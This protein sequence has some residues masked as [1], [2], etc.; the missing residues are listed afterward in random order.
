MAAHLLKFQEKQDEL[1][2]PE[3]PFILSETMKVCQVWH[4]TD[5]LKH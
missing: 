5:V 4:Y 2:P 1:H 3:V